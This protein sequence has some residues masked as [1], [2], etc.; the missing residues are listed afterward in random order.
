MNV[1]RKKLL[2]CKINIQLS[3]YQL[4]KTTFTIFIFYIWSLQNGTNEKFVLKNEQ[5][6]IEII[7]TR[8]RSWNWNLSHPNLR[9]FPLGYRVS[10]L[11]V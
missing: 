4:K 3:I 7:H 8:V 9:L 5:N 1:T 6:I 10:E 2:S 11:L